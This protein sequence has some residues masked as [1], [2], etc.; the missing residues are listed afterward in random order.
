M[1]ILQLTPE[2]MAALWLSAKVAFFCTLLILIPGV[3]LGW[4]L[5]RKRFF[6]KALL[7]SVVHLPLVLPPVVPGFLLLLLLGNQGFLGKWLQDTFGI[8]IAFTW[9]GAVVAS[10]IMALPLMVRSAR[11]AVSQVD[12]GLELAAQS[13]GAHPLRVFFS[14]TLPLALPGILTGMV[15]AFSRSLGEFGATITFVGNIE[16]ETRTLPLAIYTYTQIPGGDVPALRLVVLS[17]LLAFAALYFS[18][19][20]EQRALRRIGSGDDRA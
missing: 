17:L 9:M 16:G 12:R 15:L 20:M 6:G 2:E 13:L 3:L 10:A 19:I 7:D 18:N 1:S 5:A 14:I 11:L 8:S 4:V